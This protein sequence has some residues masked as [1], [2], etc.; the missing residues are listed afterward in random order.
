MV[1]SKNRQTKKQIKPADLLAV[2]NL[3]TY[4]EFD[5]SSRHFLTTLL[6]HFFLTTHLD[7]VKICLIILGLINID[8]FYTANFAKCLYAKRRLM[9]IFLFFIKGVFISGHLGIIKDKLC[10]INQF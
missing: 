4:H 5:D 1:L 6:Q 2:S 8:K 7:V 9:A 3:M 10:V